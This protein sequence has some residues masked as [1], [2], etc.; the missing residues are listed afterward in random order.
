MAWWSRIRFRAARDNALFDP[1][2]LPMPDWS[3]FA[4]DS[5]SAAWRDQS[6]DVITLTFTARR[7]LPDN[8]ADDTAMQ[9]HCRSVAEGQRAGLVEVA[10]ASGAEGPCLTYIYKRLDKPAF[11]FFG[12]VTA[13]VR[14]GTWVWMIVAGERGTT[15]MR[16][17][18]VTT[19]LLDD[20]TLTMESYE[21]SWAKDPYDPNYSGVE[22]STLRYMSDGPEYDAEFPHHPLSKVRRELGRLIGIQISPPWRNREHR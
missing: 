14:H 16:E 20:G 3:I 21:A 10:V 1:D 4:R 15:G 13:P 2:M 11:K 12:V 18:V 8:L 9:E 5:S 7:L 22:R 19:R 17:A 6:G